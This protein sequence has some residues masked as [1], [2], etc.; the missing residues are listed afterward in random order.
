MLKNLTLLVAAMS[1]GAGLI[2]PTAASARMGGIGGHGI[3][4]P[5]RIDAVARTSHIDSPRIEVHP[6]ITPKPAVEKALFCTVT[7]DGGYHHNGCRHWH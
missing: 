5:G 6:R 1:I 2:A 4:N 3:S 7:K